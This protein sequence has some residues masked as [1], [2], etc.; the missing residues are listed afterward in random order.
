MDQ[1]PL[2]WLDDLSVSFPGPAGPLTAVRNLSMK[3]PAAAISCL[4]GESG[5]GKSLTCRA[6][7][8]LTPEYATLNGVI[9]FQ[10]KDLL[11]L[12]EKELR[13]IRGSQI[14]MIFQEPM[15]SLNPVLTVGEQTAEPLRLHLKMN[16]KAARSR[17]IELFTQVGIPSPESRYFDYP[18][19][20]SGGMRQRV[21]IAM[22]MACG[23]AL[24]LADEPTTALDTTIQG[25][26]L[27]L[28]QAESRQRN[29]AVLLITHDLGVVADVADFTG[30]MYAGMLMEY[31][32]TS[33]LFAKPLHPYTQG[34]IAAQPS[35][36]S[37]GLK[38]LP[39]IPGVVPTLDKMPE[40]CP[41]QP[42]CARAMSVC[43]TKSPPALWQDKH[44][45]ACWLYEK[46]KI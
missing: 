4:V 27:G 29:M 7:L 24:L 18:H 12:P 34:L 10:G 32:T 13:Q 14:G 6:V 28:I 19:Q 43:A 5:C 1:A 44:M 2:L 11:E 22:A 35:R 3:L 45:V 40:G 15:T 26:I 37:I 39:A 33:E 9:R 23:P 31:A 17:V 16:K 42:R 30:V 36:A 25:Q 41:F 46:E 38:R 20:L 21:M 8:R